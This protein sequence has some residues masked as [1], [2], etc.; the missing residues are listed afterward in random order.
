VRIDMIPSTYQLWTY[1]FFSRHRLSATTPIL[2]FFPHPPIGR[3]ADFVLVERTDGP[4]PT[5]VEGPP[6]RENPQFALYRL[7]PSIPGPD[8]SSQRMFEPITKVSIS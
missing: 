4:P 3:K 7:K 8:V 1:H 5:D 6:I 2:V